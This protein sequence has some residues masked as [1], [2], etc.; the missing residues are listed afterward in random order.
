MS[1]FRDG[2]PCSRAKAAGHGCR[3]PLR[4]WLAAAALLAV[5]LVGLAL[6]LL[7]RVLPEAVDPTWARIQETGVLRVCTDPSWPPFE[8]IDEATGQLQGFDVE[9]AGTWPSGWGAMGMGAR[10]CRP[11]W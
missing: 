8:F 5:V 3:H 10:P 4:W 6:W 11:R 7:L 9:L 2:Q 1:Q